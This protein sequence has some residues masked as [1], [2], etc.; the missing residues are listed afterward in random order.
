LGGGSTELVLGDTEVTACY[1]MDVG[2]VRLTER[3]LQ[4]D[5]PTASEITAAEADVAA[6]LAA[7]AQ[8]VPLQLAATIV[9]VAGTVTSLTAYHLGLSTYDPQAVDGTAVTPDDAERLSSQMLALT[10]AERLDLGFMQPG[11]A[12]IIGAGALIWRAVVQ[13]TTAAAAAAGHEIK[14][15][16]TRESDM[17][18]GIAAALAA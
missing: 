18:E 1:S 11:R 2:S 17:L 4:T 16:V 6:V 5:P 12:D 13:A 9:G 15:V 3:R 8:V 10:K 7:A 14:Q